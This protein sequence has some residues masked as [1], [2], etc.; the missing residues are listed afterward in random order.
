[1]TQFHP[2]DAAAEEVQTVAADILERVTDGFFALDPQGRFIYVNRSA[3]R[4]LGRTR[5]ELL[6]WSFWQMFPEATERRIFRKYQRAVGELVPVEFEDT[7]PALGRT[8]RVRLFPS[9]QGVSVY[10]RDITEEKQTQ[11][12]LRASEE[13]FRQIAEHVREIL[14]LITPDAEQVLYVSPAFDTIWGVPREQLLADAGAWTR[15]IHPGDRERVAAAIPRM[16]EGT[17][18]EQ[19]RIMSRG[20]A[21]R[22]IRDRAFPVRN[23]AGD[24]HRI[25]GVAEDITSER[26][27]E[28]EREGLF[29]REREAREVA[30]RAAEWREEV[31]AIVSHDLKNPLHSIGL[32]AAAMRDLPLRED[33]RSEMLD[34]ILAVTEQMQRLIQGLLDTSRI[35]AGHQLP[36]EPGPVSVDELLRDACALFRPQVLQRQIALTCS[37]PDGCPDVYADRDRILQ[38]FWNLIGNAVKFTPEAGHVSVSA[39]PEGASVR[40]AVT[41]SGPGIPPEHMDRLFDPFWQEKRTARLGTGL[42]LPISRALVAS[43]GGRIWVESEQGRGTTFF[44]TLPIA[45]AE[46]IP[47]RTAG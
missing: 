46:P 10:F 47:S 21:V 32:T 36:V 42:G 7:V 33:Q 11:E 13:Q 40:F 6:G 20:G 43:H 4:I 35:E 30:E 31:L 9:E 17:Y 23:D 18:D 22:W 2:R 8:F 44:F 14:Y 26:E 39:Q 37:V 19:Y 38:V 27:A 29:A 16:K 25:V 34:R 15:T 24:V 45:P 12:E 1:M 28:L 3:E 5:D 41:D